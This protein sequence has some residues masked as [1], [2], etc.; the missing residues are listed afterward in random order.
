MKGIN[1]AIFATAS[2]FLLSCGGG[3]SSKINN[4]PNYLVSTIVGVN[5]T[6]TPTSISVSQN[7]I[8]SFTITPN[9]GYAVSSIE[10]CN[11]SLSDNIYTTGA[12]NAP[13]T[14]SVNFNK[15][16]TTVFE[17]SAYEF[18]H[19]GQL[20]DNVCKESESTS[21]FTSILLPIDMNKNGSNDLLVHYWCS[22]KEYGN[23]MNT[24]TPDALVAFKNNG[25]KTFSIANTEIFSAKEISFGAGTRKV[26]KA[27]FNGDGFD[28]ILYALNREDGR[29]QEDGSTNESDQS[30][31]LSK[32]DGTY[33]IL[34]LSFKEWT[35][36]VDAV[37]LPSGIYD[38]VISG[39]RSNNVHGFRYSDGLISQ[40]NIYSNPGGP[41]GRFGASTMRFFPESIAGSGSVLAISDSGDCGIQ[42][43]V[44]AF[45]KESGEWKFINKTNFQCRT[46]PDSYES[47][48]GEL[49]DL[50][51]VT[52]DGQDYTG[53]GFGNEES[54]TLELSPGNP[55]VA[56]VQ[57]SAQPI[58]GNHIDGAIY[59]QGELQTENRLNFYNVGSDGL[60]LKTD[61]LVDEI[62]DVFYRIDSCRDINNDGYDDIVLLQNTGGGGE[63]NNTRA[64]PIIYLNNQA[65]QLVRINL[66]GIP[67]VANNDNYSV[68]GFLSDLN[69]DGIEDLI[70]FRQLRPSINGTSLD[71]NKKNF[72]RVH[73]GL[74]N[75][76][77]L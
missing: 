2:I 54:C 73:F 62:T 18:P 63:Q 35:H 67:L 49:G 68:H 24:R 36:A 26:V 11:G 46:I 15:F 4:L 6:I 69:G 41:I 5:G 22:P 48:T 58:E 17:T 64:E 25:D 9:S 21:I 66:E 31:I 39:F 60:S 51:L 50:P 37:Q 61:V 14:V 30:V 59:K 8:T 75:I 16:M 65:D 74:K 47:Y 40:T 42:A 43:N 70:W 53:G 34:D 7:Q 52:I 33:D 3:S 28:D 13:C 32:G 77:I 56:A 44:S 23:Y 55:R 38:A 45:S 10:G 29:A 27:D 12:I 71:P 19:P 72:I 20:I 57:F 76:N 1:I